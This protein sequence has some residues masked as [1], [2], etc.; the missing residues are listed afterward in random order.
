MKIE[1]PKELRTFAFTDFFGALPRRTA[2]PAMMLA[3]LAAIAA[4]QVD[5]TDPATTLARIELDAV[6]GLVG[7]VATVTVRSRIPSSAA[8]WRTFSPS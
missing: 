5:L 7:T 1:L 4:G 6:V 3:L 8:G 2:A